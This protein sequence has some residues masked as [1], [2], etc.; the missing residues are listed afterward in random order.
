MIGIVRVAVELTRRFYPI[1]RTLAGFAESGRIGLRKQHI[2]GHVHTFWITRVLILI[3]KLILLRE[4]GKSCRCTDSLSDGNSR[5]PAMP[6]S[7]V[8]QRGVL[9]NGI[10]QV[11]PLRGL[12]RI[13]QFRMSQSAAKVL[14]GIRSGEVVTSRCT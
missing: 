11:Q 1:Q 13:E 3:D 14:A 8:R 9:G 2:G 12:A 6:V 7:R 4:F 5:D 10:S